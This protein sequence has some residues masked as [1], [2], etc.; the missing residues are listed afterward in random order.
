[1]TQRVSSASTAVLRNQREHHRIPSAKIRKGHPLLQQEASEHDKTKS[2]N[3]SGKLLIV[4]QRM[5]KAHGPDEAC[6]TIQRLDSKTKPRI[7][8]LSPNTYF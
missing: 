3:G 8:L 6:A 1:M 5:S 7:V 4:T 2:G